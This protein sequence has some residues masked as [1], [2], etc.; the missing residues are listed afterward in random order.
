MTRLPRIEILRRKHRRSIEV[1]TYIC[2]YIRRGRERRNKK[3]IFGVARPK[4]SF[5][6][7][8]KFIYLKNIQGNNS[9][10][11][12]HDGSVLNIL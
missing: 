2:I 8:C 3:D 10:L 11:S 9:F 12:C 5:C 1:G 7:G 6:V 4:F